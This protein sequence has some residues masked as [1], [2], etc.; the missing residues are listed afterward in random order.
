LISKGYK[1]AICEQLTD[2]KKT[3]G[4]FERGVIRV[5]TPG[6]VIEDTMLDEKKDNYLLSIYLQDDKIGIATTDVSTGLFTV[7]EVDG[8]QLDSAFM[9]EIARIQPTEIIANEAL[10]LRKEL[11]APLQAKY[12][13]YCYTIVRDMESAEELLK[14]RFGARS[15]KEL[16]I[17]QQPCTAMAAAV[18]LD[19]LLNTQKNPLEHI[20]KLSIIKHSQYMVLD[21][22]TRRNLELTSP[23]FVSGGRKNTLLSLLDAT[24]TAMGGRLLRRWI[25]QPLQ[26]RDAI[27]KRLDAVEELKNDIILWQ[28]VRDMLNKIYDIER[29]CSKIVYGSVNARDC[30]ALKTSLAVLPAL[31]TALANIHSPALTK[32]CKAL[33]T[34]EDVYDTLEHAIEPLPP[35]SVKEGGIIRSKYNEEVDRLRS[36]SID[37]KTWLAKLEASERE[38]TGIKNLR[39]GYNR[40]FGYYIEVTKS[41][42]QL[43]PYNYQ[44][45]QTLAGAERYITSE[46]KQLESDILG[47]TDKCIELEYELFTAIRE[48]LNKNITRLQASAS[49]VA[50]IDVFQTLA[51]VA[52]Q[53]NYCKPKINASGKLEIIDGRHPVVE[54]TVKNMFVPNST[55]MDDVENRLQVITGPNMAGK[56]TYMRQVALI[57]LMAHIGSFV[58]AKEANIPLTDR[59]F[60]RVGASDDLA[61]GQST[62]MVEMAELAHIL[63]NATQQSLLILD[64]IGRGTSTF[65]GLSIAWAVIEHIAEYYQKGAKTLFATHYHELSELEGLLPG[66]KNYRISVKEVG[67]DIIFLRKVIRGSADRSFGIQVAQLA[68]IPDRIIARAKEI[69]NQLESADINK[70]LFREGE[71]QPQ[72]PKQ[73]QLM[74]TDESEILSTLKDIDFDRLTPIQALNILY[75]LHLKAQALLNKEAFG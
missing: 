67:D 68:G 13:I 27:N 35:I 60:T 22:V 32:L 4:L 34:L 46:L 69:L 40:V 16:G 18:L 70:G 36:I 8:G 59:I 21:A 39:I 62:F 54:R 37:G 30:V 49:A 7:S 15:L 26:A 14:A 12:Y 11:I 63:E 25:D 5:I 3:K 75:D 20:N 61:A 28:N 24:Q 73:I 42:Q 9:D 64:E 55:I 47:A 31:K 74:F 71:A 38:K 1:V 66:I 48:Y 44:R 2:P 33:D 19:Y 50:G 29:L 65:D 23:L 6:T 52:S 58:P 56:S 51:G 41:Y 72:P 45:K 10:F 53:N 43:V 17:D 57:V